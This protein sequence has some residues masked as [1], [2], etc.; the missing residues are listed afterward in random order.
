MS[1][2]VSSRRTRDPWYNPALPYR[3]YDPKKAKQLLAEAGY[4]NGFKT[5][6]VSDV[7]ARKDTLVAIQTYLK[8]V[9]IE[10]ELEVLEFGAAFVKPKQGWE[11]I[12]FP[13][14][15]QCGHPCRHSGAL[16]HRRT[17][18][19]ASTGRRDGRRSGTPCSLSWIEKKL[20]GQMKEHDKDPL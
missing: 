18:M 2:W 4:P 10:T 20:M 5:K 1:R 8:E 14:F 3:E 16:G 12:Y 11:G 19:S 6:L 15:P 9:G 7:M 17:T 13:G